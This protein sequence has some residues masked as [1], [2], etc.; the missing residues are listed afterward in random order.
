MPTG[1]GRSARKLF[2]RRFTANRCPGMRRSFSKQFDGGLAGLLRCTGASLVLGACAGGPQMPALPSIGVAADVSKIA[3][4]SLP[5]VEPQRHPASSAEIYS[6]IARGA[7]A[8]WFGARGRIAKSHILHADAAPSMNGGGVEIV[9]H[10]RAVDQ[11]K[12]WG[13]KAFR[14]ML[15]ESAGLDGS[16]GAGGTS[17]AVENTRIPDAE[18]LR[19]RA[20]VFQWASGTEGCKA[21]PTLDKAPEPAAPAPAAAAP[22]AKTAARKSPPKA[23]SAASPATAK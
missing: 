2:S 7:N 19:M 17:I 18:A 15:T 22:A 10:E 9:V 13:Y 21:D 11:P 23:A 3:V 8:C 1:H 12:P 20:E 14:V 5:G 6:R 4:G 16:P